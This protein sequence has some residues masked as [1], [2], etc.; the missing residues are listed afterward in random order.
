MGRVVTDRQLL[1]R[2]LG[3][4]FVDGLVALAVFLAFIWL[5]LPALGVCPP[6][7]ASIEGIVALVAVF[8]GCGIA[9]RIPGE[10]KYGVSVGKWLFGLRVVGVDTMLTPR[11]ALVRNILRPIDFLPAGYLIGTLL[12]VRSD[13][14]QRLGDLAA[15]TTVVRR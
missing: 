4:T 3:A 14:A 15:G 1:V 11:A 7:G 9:V 13:H 6:M 10:A 5:L 8:F 12:I 2:R